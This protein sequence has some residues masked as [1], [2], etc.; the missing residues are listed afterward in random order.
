MRQ[1]LE[2]NVQERWVR[3]QAG[4]IKDQLNAFLKPY[5]FFFAP[6]FV[7]SN[8]ATIGGMVNTVLQ[9]RVR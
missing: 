6:D 3:V 5:G 8:R 2:L 1:I 7:D 9:V 4:V